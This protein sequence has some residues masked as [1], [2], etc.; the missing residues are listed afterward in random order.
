MKHVILYAVA[1]AALAAAPAVGQNNDMAA[2]NAAETATTNADTTAAD[3]NVAAP[4]EP[5]EAAPPAE[6]P[7]TNTVPAPAPQPKSFPW[8]VLGLL[9]LVGLMGS[10]KGS[11]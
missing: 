2:N 7:V 6:T 1:L 4:A 11:S 3:T 5:A 8:G 9:G 10:R